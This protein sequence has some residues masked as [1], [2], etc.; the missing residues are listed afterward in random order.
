MTTAH[1]IQ[2]FLQD[3]TRHRCRPKTLA[4][5][6]RALGLLEQ[7][8]RTEH[9]SVQLGQMTQAQVGGWFVFL[10]EQ[11]TATG[12]LR[13]ANTVQSYARSARAFCHWA[14]RQKYLCSTPFAYL[15]LPQ[16]EHR[17]FPLLEPEE[18]E[19]LLLACHALQETGIVAD[20]AA[21]RNRAIL[22]VLFETGMQVTEVCRLRLGDVDREQKV[23]SVWGSGSKA[24]HLMLGPEGWHHLL[25]Y[26]DGYRLGAV[27]SGERGWG[28]SDPLFLS[29]TG[30]PLTKS[31][32]T[33]LFGRL[34]KRAGITG[35]GVTASLL[36][37]SFAMRYLQA[38]G[39][40]LT[41][42]RLLGYANQTTFA[43]SHYPSAQRVWSTNARSP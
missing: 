22:W 25:V 35:E 31:G 30:G 28:S 24:R 43:R 13:S 8:L 16:Q 34:R 10:Q 27:A 15:P 42:Q 4:W 21:A 20:Q 41:L 18:W 3:Q 19:R 9:H 39:N 36:R 26:L 11:P 32:V 5:H 33:L 29:E 2:D 1:A 7:Y 37:K 14:V 23:L 40:P 12:S 17:V 38:G 6:Q